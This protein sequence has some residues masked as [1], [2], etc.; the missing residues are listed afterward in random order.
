M[1]N[2]FCF[3]IPIF[4][5]GM[6]VLAVVSAKH[7]KARREALAALAAELGV[8]FDPD[9]RSNRATAYNAFDLFDRGH[10]RR[11]YNT[12][13]GHVDLGGHRLY[14]RIGDYLYKTTS[15]S[16][17][18]RRTHTHH[19]SYLLLDL[20]QDTPDIQIRPEHFFD[21]MASAIG[22]NDLDF[23]SVEFSDAFHVKASDE[24]FAYDLFHPRMMELLLRERP[25]GLQMRRGL[26]LL[27]GGGTWKVEQFRPHVEFVRQFIEH[28]PRHLLAA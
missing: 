27:H 15:G 9:S 24:R 19:H 21:R 18:N 10:G 4:I 20:P 22:F 6:I 1:D 3:I 12:L 14:V 17:K 13:E 5:V 8:H 28:W 16:G 25:P 7:A 26:L 23:E 2:A 11:L